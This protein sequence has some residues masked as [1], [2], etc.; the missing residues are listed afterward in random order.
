MIASSSANASFGSQLSRN[1]G[2]LIARRTFL[3]RIVQ[4]NLQLDAATLLPSLFFV[5]WSMSFSKNLRAAM[6]VGQ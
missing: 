4:V 2:M 3:R 6:R 1:S 5:H